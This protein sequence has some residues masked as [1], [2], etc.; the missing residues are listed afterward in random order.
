MGMN[1]KEAITVLREAISDEAKAIAFFES[2]RWGDSPACPRC[3]SVAVHQVIG[4]D[5]QRERHFRWKCKD[6]KRQYSVRTGT[7]F[8]ETRMPMRTWAHIYWRA[9]ASKK[10]VSALQIS[11]ECAIGY[12]HALFALNRIRFAMDDG[13]AAPKLTGI[14]EADE[15]YVGGKPRLKHRQAPGEAPRIVRDKPAVLAAV[16]RGGAVRVRAVAKVTASTL[17]LFLRETADHGIR[18]MTDDAPLYE[19]FGKLFKGG[20]ERVRHTAREYV[21]G[22]V[23]TNTV[24]GFFSILKRKVY[25]THHAISREHLHRYIAEAA[26][27]YN[28]RKLTDAD[29]VACAVKSSEGKRLRYSDAPSEAA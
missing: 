9:C 7:V 25:G 11:R 14:V 3:G 4:T 8:E 28:T 12:R 27:L 6:C 18:L 2:R 23:T 29:R 24:E 17:E 5:G 20:H 22:D 15:T 13:A 21:R 10:G 1:T 19:R 16:Q 26:F